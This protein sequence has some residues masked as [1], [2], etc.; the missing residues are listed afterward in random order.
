MIKVVHGFKTDK[1]LSS[2]QASR[3]EL[4][5]QIKLKAGLLHNGRIEVAQHMEKREMQRAKNKVLRLIQETHRSDIMDLLE[6]YC[7][8]LFQQIGLIKSAKE[9]DPTL[10]EPVSTVIWAA[11]RLETEVPSLMKVSDQLIYKYSKEYGEMC[12]SNNAG[13][14]NAEVMTKLSASFPHKSQ[15]FKYLEGI[16]KEFDLNIQQ[17]D[18]YADAEYI[19]APSRNPPLD[20]S[21]LFPSD[22]TYLPRRNSPY[23]K[24]ALYEA[25]EHKH[26][27]RRNSP[28]DDVEPWHMQ[29]PSALKQSQ[30]VNDRRLN[31]GKATPPASA[32]NSDDLYEE[33]N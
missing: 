17:E 8:T 3:K 24:G 30:T 7:S 23:E 13:T 33:V 32:S 1:I 6:F 26:G 21:E 27:P 14:V 19:Y 25:D 4:N 12:R 9:L 29:R 11:P 2:I 5:E 31:F 18:I 22:D 20:M 28:Y 15:I 10:V 16:S